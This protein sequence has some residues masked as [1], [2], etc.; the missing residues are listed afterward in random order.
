MQNIAIRHSNISF[1]P[2][3]SKHVMEIYPHWQKR[4]L[5]K[6]VKINEMRASIVTSVDSGYTTVV[7]TPLSQTPHARFVNGDKLAYKKYLESFGNTVGYGKE[8]SSCKFLELI[9]TFRTYL[10][11]K[12]THKYII[13]YEKKA[14]FGKQYIILDGLH[15][16]AILSTR[17]LGRIPICVIQNND[18]R[19]LEQLDQYLQDYKDDF[20]EWYTP[21]QIMGRVIH[22]RTYPKYVVRRAYL[23]NKERGESKWDY[24]I[25]DNLP[26]IKGKRVCDLGCNVGLYSIYLSQMGAK[27]VDGYDR[28][29]TIVQPTNTELPK[30]NVVQQAYFVRN[31][32][33]LAKIEVPDSVC[34]FE[35]DLASL[36]FSKLKYDLLFS[37]CVLYHFGKKKF[38][39]F[40]SKVSSHIPEIFLQT[41]LGHKGGELEETA[42]LAFHRMVLEKYGYKVII[43]A[44]ENYNYPIIYGKKQLSAA[45]NKS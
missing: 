26:S 23:T 21:I 9:K 17:N 14:I 35:Q 30:Q 29:E 41:N 11:S 45:R 19:P 4:T 7:N 22:E 20:L 32:H 1:K 5:I 18:L 28:T 40:I 6:R 39:E 44:P 12:H 27:K 15:R 38:N 3:L 24:I 37:S 2:K 25:K 31:L 33:R 34:F 16:A 42:S 8:H 10:D 13:C 36:D 43:V